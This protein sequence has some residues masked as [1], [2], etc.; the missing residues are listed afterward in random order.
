MRRSQ[1]CDF[2]CKE[3]A[4][5]AVGFALAKCGVAKSEHID[6]LSKL[7]V[8]V[9]LPAGMLLVGLVLSEYKLFDLF[10]RPA[11]YVVSVLRLFVVPPAIG[12]VLLLF[13]NDVL[14]RD[15][16]VLYAMPCGLNTVV[17]VKNVGGD[18]RPG[19]VLALVSNILA[20]LS[21][22]LVLCVFGISA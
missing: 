2:S 9:F 10:R 7:L 14:L 13:K 16:V 1:G 20:C 17:F 12:A 3:A 22:P 19:A 6:L 15:A 11:V 8:Y 21:I 18:C 4:F 5:A